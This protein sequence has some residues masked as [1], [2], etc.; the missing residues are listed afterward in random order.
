MMKKLFCILSLMAL[1]TAFA[2]EKPTSDI[3]CGGKMPGT[4]T[5]PLDFSKSKNPPSRPS[6]KRARITYYPA[7]GAKD[8]GLVIVC[9][10][11]GYSCLYSV[12][13]EG[14]KIAEFFNKKGISAAVLEYRVPNNFDGALQDAQ[15][16]VRLVRSKAKE[17][18]INPNK[19]AIMGF[20]AGASLAARTSTNY[21]ENSY[22]PIDEIDKLSSKPD[23]TI[24]IYPAYCSQPEKDRR[25]G[26]QKAKSGDYSYLYEIADWNKIDKNTPPA[27]I[28]QSQ[29]DPYLDA[30]IAYYLA[31]KNFDVPAELHLISKGKH[32][33]KDP[34][35]FDV[36]AKCL[37]ARGF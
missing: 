23:Y 13:G 2:Q 36:M 25:M 5:E 11:G 31:L 28:T 10:G 14:F 18:N 24:L 32:G 20:S 15:R 4:V 34:D 6:I 21:A 27:F 9:P 35:M 29:F 3:W 12:S 26:K 8:G 7:E 19:I 22:A 33:Y 30:A 17:L 16:A 1:A 37:K